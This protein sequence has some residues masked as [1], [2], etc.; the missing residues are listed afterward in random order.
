I[1]RRLPAARDAQMAELAPQLL[2]PQ[3]DRV[4]RA[5]PD[6][7]HPDGDGD[8]DGADGGVRGPER[9]CRLRRRRDG[10]L[11]GEFCLPPDEAAVVDAGLAAARDAE[12]GDRHD[13]DP[14]GPG[15]PGGPVGGP[16]G[17]GVSW[18][19]GLVRMARVATD[20]LDATLQ[21]TGRPGD[22]HQIVLHHDIDPDGTLGS[23]QLELGP[24]V[25]DT[26]ARFL[27][28]DA[29]VQLLVYRLGELVGIFPSQ[30]TPSRA[31]RRYLA[32]RDQG[33]AHP[34]CTQRRGLHAHHI[35]HWEDGGATVPA[36]LVLLCPYH[37]RA[38]HHGAFRITGNPETGTLRFLDHH[39]QPIGPPP[40]P[41][42]PP[43]GEQPP[44]AGTYTPPLA[45]PLPT[46][47]LTWN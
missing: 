1:A 16:G 6:Q 3:L 21:R 31:L 14:T 13:L 45:E 47:T 11:R 2:I 20:A 46:H 18:A 25:P 12:F 44:A 29:S 10:W 27:A 41:P 33:C 22:R 32:R 43:P 19:D 35:R 8:G 5:L 30:R 9:M 42:P 24:V 7:P 28:C 38:L 37:H 40:P 4:L 23:G 15:D 17:W 39:D 34:T 26:V 36:N